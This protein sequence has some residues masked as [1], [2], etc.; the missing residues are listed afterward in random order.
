MSNDYSIDT[1]ITPFPAGS[2]PSSVSAMSAPTVFGRRAV[3]DRLADSIRSR[4]S[5]IV[6]APPGAGLSTL[7]H[8]AAVEARA[9]QHAV[10][11]VRFPD[12]RLG[13]IDDSPDVVIVTDDA[14]RADEM[15]ALA[16]RDRAVDAPVLVGARR[17]A[18]NDTLSWLWRS[19]I[20]DLVELAPLDRETTAELV[21]SLLGGAVHDSLVTGVHTRSAGRPGFAVDEVE[22][23]RADGLDAREAGL[24]RERTTGRVGSRLEERARCLLAELPSPVAT[25]VQVLAVAGA[26]PMTALDELQLDHGELVR[27][28]LAE[29]DMRAGSPTLRL[30]PP[31]LASAVRAGSSTTFVHQWATTLLHSESIPLPAE[32]RARLRIQLGER[33]ELGEIR[34]AAWTAITEREPAKAVMLAAQCTR[35][36]PRR[37]DG[38]RRRVEQR[39]EPGGGCRVLRPRP[40]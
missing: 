17:A 11:F 23:M 30:V 26:L 19:G 10:R 16:L 31:S 21:G 8:T 24:I 12:P 20:A 14:H 18:I 37:A 3:L 28:Q 5:V 22:S 7:L 34:A 4:R 36:W 13:T 39:R 25:A 2:L 15:Q 9:E 6:L 1:A 33:L 27:R 29:A 32:D 38:R 35:P 40:A